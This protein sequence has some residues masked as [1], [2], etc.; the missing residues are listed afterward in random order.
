MSA[1]QGQ[2][3][4]S[5]FRPGNYTVTHVGVNGVVE[6]TTP[7]HQ[8]YIDPRKLSKQWLLIADIADCGHTFYPGFQHTVEDECGHWIDVCPDC[9]HDG[10]AE[11]VSRA[12][13]PRE[14]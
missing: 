14:A 7:G 6:L 11:P 4:R 10:P 12:A 2:I 9:Y 3:Y 1:K 13:S 8:T 5:Q